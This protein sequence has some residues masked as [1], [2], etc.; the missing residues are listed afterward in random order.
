MQ[1]TPIQALQ[2]RPCPARQTIMNGRESRQ[3]RAVL[4]TL[5]S[6]VATTRS[7]IFFFSTN[8]RV[9]V[10]FVNIYI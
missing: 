5:A 2:S 3:V 4:G 9:R 8:F 10:G 1:I 6:F 7:H